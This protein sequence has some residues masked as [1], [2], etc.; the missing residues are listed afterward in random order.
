MKTSTLLAFLGG[1]A[2]GAGIAL[3]FTTEEGKKA[4][5]AVKD[6]LDKGIDRLTDK[7]EDIV[8]KQHDV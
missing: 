2:L 5:N 6:T 4:C 7:I 8:Y 1:A 3:L